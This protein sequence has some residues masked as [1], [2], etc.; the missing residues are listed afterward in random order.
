MLV[1]V[2]HMNPLQTAQ[3]FDS[4]IVK[5][6]QHIVDVLRERIGVEDLSKLIVHEQVYD[7]RSWK[8]AFNLD[9]GSILGLSH[10]FLWVP[11]RD[12]VCCSNCSDFLFGAAT[13][14][15][16]DPRR[17]TVKSRTATSQAPVLIL[18]QGAF[19]CQCLY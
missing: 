18:A 8:E 17:G 5:A 16:S 3:D 19:R 15:R 7:P 14:C 12:R 10:D 1:P 6:R 4:M 9:K 11:A 2:G 13:Y